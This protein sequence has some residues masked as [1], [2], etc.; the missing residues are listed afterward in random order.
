VNA[1]V[2]DAKL[3]TI[4]LADGMAPGWLEEFRIACD[5]LGLAHRII[6]VK[7]NGWQEQLEGLDAFVW[8]PIMGDPS[9]MALIRAILPLIESMGITCF[10]NAMMLWLYN[11]KIRETFFL[12]QHGYPMPATF[13]SY[14]EQEAVAFAKQATYPIITK[15]HMGASS[16]GVKLL[17][18]KRKALSLLR[19]VFAKPSVLDKALVKYYYIPRLKKGDF[20]LERRFRFR[21]FCPRYAYFQEFIETGE[22]WRITTLGQNLISIFVRRNRPGDFRASGSGLWEKLTENKLPKEACDMALEIS[23]Y[24]RFTSMTYDFMPGPNGW[25]IGEISFAFVLNRIYCDTLF[26]RTENGYRAVEPI[27]I[28]EMHL[29]AMIEKESY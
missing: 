12:R 10:P 4:G 26:R 25:V 22:D 15:T 27:P 13:I 17:R 3:N 8:R 1:R 29:K 11:D 5:R 7:R 2:E 18:T 14:D 9:N 23:N 24:H 19:H 20:L 6:S 21:D 28:G 16:S